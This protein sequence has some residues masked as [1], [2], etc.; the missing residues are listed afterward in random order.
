MFK[1][2]FTVDNVGVDYDCYF[3]SSYL[4]LGDYNRYKDIPYLQI[5]FYR[6]EEGNFYDGSFILPSSVKV[7]SRWDWTASGDSSKW[8]SSQETYRFRSLSTAN[9]CVSTSTRLR[10]SGQSLQL[11]FSATS[12]KDMR[13]NGIGL[14]AEGIDIV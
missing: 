2:W 9:N 5:N 12:G 3:T 11:N 6:T 8:S 13:I 4:N 7:Q 1:D 14:I 10:G